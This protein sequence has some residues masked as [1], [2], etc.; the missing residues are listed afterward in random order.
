[1]GNLAFY[2][3]NMDQYSLGYTGNRVEEVHEEVGHCKVGH[4][5]VDWMVGGWCGNQSS[6]H[7]DKL[8]GCNDG[9]L[10][11]TQDGTCL[12]RPCDNKTEVHVGDLGIL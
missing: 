11:E 5:R 12:D 10:S 3:S 4:C 6:T 2:Q 7:W 1:M 9:N 8:V